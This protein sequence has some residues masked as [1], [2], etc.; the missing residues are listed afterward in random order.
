MTPKKLNTVDTETARADVEKWLD[1]RRVTEKQRA[2]VADAVN[3][4]VELFESG[5]LR[6][7]E[8]TE[9]VHTLIFPEYC[10]DIEELTYK[11]RIR[12]DEIEQCRALAKKNETEYQRAI[13]A[14]LANI[15]PAE[16]KGMDAADWTIAQ[17]VYSFF[18]IL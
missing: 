9:I 18:F 10:N 1:I 17:S 8:N 4:L 2:N 3:T 12:V 15:A 11:T 13:I 6:L 16:I 5:R 14:K 7:N